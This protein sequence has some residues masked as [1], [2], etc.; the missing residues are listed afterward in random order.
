[1]TQVGA[2]VGAILSA[3]AE[4]VRLIGYGTYVGSKIPEEAVGWMA[5]GL[6]EY[7]VGNP[8]I[9]LDSGQVV[10]GCECWFGPESRIREMI[11]G[12]RVIEVDID[13][14]RANAMEGAEGSG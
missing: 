2:R 6:R 9:E 4:E 12:R 1:M 8:C 7:G 10:Y 3:N 13:Q 5:E 11:G 14:V